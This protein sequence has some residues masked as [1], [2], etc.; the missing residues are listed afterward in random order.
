MAASS[1]AEGLRLAH[2]LQPALIT[3]DVMMPQ[4][5]G[6]SVLR[7]LKADPEL[8]DIPVVMLTMLE[9]QSKAYSL[10]ATDYL[11]KPIERDQLRRVV[12]RYY[13]EG[14]LSM[15]LLVDDDQ[16][17]RNTVSHALK[18]GGWTVVQAANGQEALESLSEKSPSLILL[19]LMMPVMDGFDFLIE[20][21][22]DER[23]RDIP[24]IVL[25]AKDLT[26]E[27][28][29]VL[30][31]RVEQVFEKDAKSHDQLLGLISNLAQKA[32]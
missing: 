32:S 18:K 17:A 1:G 14:E 22:A 15:A 20:K 7:A 30:S 31:G 5:D 10:G 9:D 23:W 24:V 4:M 3:L 21:H 29:R 16:A 12:S 11:V 6:W 8:R 13:S 28:K 26:E 19:D 27:D 2:E 25:T